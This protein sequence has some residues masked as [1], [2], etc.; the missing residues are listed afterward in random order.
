MMRRR[1]CC[2]RCGRL[3]AYTERCGSLCTRCWHDRRA[4]VLD[5]L[6]ALDG[7]ASGSQRRLMFALW[8]E[9]G[10]VDRAYRLAVTSAIVDRDVRTSSTLT[11]VEASRI[12]DYL[13]GLVSQRDTA[14]VAVQNG[15]L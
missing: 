10:I 11:K 13:S 2:I 9:V 8:S 3:L 4:V 5:R 1:L 15:S 14:D 7:L 12:A 6:R